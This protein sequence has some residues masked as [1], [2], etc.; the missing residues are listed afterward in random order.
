MYTDHICPDPSSGTTLLSL[1]RRCVLAIETA[2]V[3]TF[4]EP[5][6]RAL[7]VHQ[8]MTTT[9]ISTRICNHKSMHTYFIHAASPNHHI[10]MA[11]TS[12]SSSSP[13]FVLGA[14]NCPRAKLASDAK[15][16]F[17]SSWRRIDGSTP[18][19]LL[20]C[21]VLSNEARSARARSDDDDRS[22]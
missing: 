21:A 19:N 18:Q 16:G 14:S 17:Q 4:H 15:R 13:L 11:C 2:N 7:C 9:N 20:P 22:R 3:F 1:L 12:S 8:T 6:W 10:I 5:E